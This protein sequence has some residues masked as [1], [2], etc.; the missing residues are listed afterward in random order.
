MKHQDP[1]AM[2]RSA[3]AI[4]LN[5]LSVNERLQR[6]ALLLESHEGPV[7][8]LDRIEYMS[9]RDRRAVRG[10]NTPMSVAF[11]DPVFRAQGLTGDTLGETM[12]FFDLTDHDAHRMFCDCH[13]NGSMT[14]R[15]LAAR[16]RHHADVRERGTLF[17]RIARMIFGRRPAAA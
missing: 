10:L 13:Y 9:P 6:W 5:D 11:A 7:H 15:N 1:L 14:G 12:S 3:E 8:A 2:E 16:L 4:S 17:Q